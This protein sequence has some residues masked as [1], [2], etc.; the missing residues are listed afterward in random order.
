M[1]TFHPIPSNPRQGQEQEKES[2][3]APSFEVGF[4][5]LGKWDAA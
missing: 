3:M 4:A 1:P 5:P 2:D